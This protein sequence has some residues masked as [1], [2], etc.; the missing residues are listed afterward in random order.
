MKKYELMIIINPSL[1]DEERESLI[2]EIKNELESFKLKI[3]NEDIVWSKD[4]AYK[5]NNSLTWFYIIYNL[6]SDSNDFFGL[7]KSL[8]IKKNIWRHLFLKIE[9]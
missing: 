9:E 8:N 2:Q 6:E 7:I 1:N 3:T 5:I 4:L